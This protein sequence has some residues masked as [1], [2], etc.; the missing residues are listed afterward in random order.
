MGNLSF[1]L[2]L[3]PIMEEKYGSRAILIMILV[4]AFI[5]GV[6]NTL[7][8][9]TSLVGASGIVFMMILLSSFTNIR[10]KEIPL[11]FILVTAI[12][13]SNEL[14]NIFKDNNISEFAH[15]MGG[16]CGSI[17]GLKFFKK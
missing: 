10:E 12:F 15:L 2:L 11:T 9:D 3:G 8:F 17:F 7:I 16:G 4:T 1:I 14:V 13:V 5:T 6:L